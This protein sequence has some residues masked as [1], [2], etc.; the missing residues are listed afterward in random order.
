MVKHL[1]VISCLLGACLLAMPARAIEPSNDP[2][3]RKV[4]ACMDRDPSTAGMMQCLQQ[5]YADWDAELNAVYA[6]VRMR[7][8]PQAQSALKDAQRLWISYRDAE[9]VAIDTIYGAMQGTMWQLAGLSRKVEFLK[10][11][12]IELRM[13]AEDLNQAN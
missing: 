4:N 3:D 7:L 9:F 6:D 2:I 8:D 1:I 12:V 11:R 5:A 10:N 13:Y